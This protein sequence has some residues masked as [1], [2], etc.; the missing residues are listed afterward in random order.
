MTCVFTNQSVAAFPWQFPLNGGKKISGNSH[1]ARPHCEEDE[2]T[3]FP[4]FDA[5]CQERLLHFSLLLL[6]KSMRPN[7][8]CHFQLK[9]TGLVPPY[10]IFSWP[11]S[12]SAF[13]LPV[14][15]CDNLV[16]CNFWAHGKCILWDPG[17]WELHHYI[18]TVLI[19]RKCLLKHTVKKL[20]PLWCHKGH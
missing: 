12:V 16:L 1:P 17:E 3:K 7:I 19:I 5:V 6:L 8:R 18:S 10:I 20:C 2:G 4:V 15:N 14:F 11:F 13:P 9:W